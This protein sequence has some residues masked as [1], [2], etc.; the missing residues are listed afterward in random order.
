MRYWFLVLFLTT[1][2]GAQPIL[3]P[4]TR[5]VV[6]VVTES[7]QAPTGR[8]SL[9]E[10]QEKWR[11]VGQTVPVTVGKS[12]L[13]WGLGLHRPAP[14]PVKKEGDGRAPAGMFSITHLFGFERGD[15]EPGL[16]W[17]E[18]DEQECVD[19]H[20][21]LHYNQIVSD[22]EVARDWHSSEQMRIPLYRL[23]LVVA[24]NPERVPGAGSCIFIHRWRSAGAPTVG[25]TALDPGEL[26]RV[27]RF[28]SSRSKPI[29]I[30]L[31][32]SVLEGWSLPDVFKEF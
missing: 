3:P 14:G 31:P 26:D 15:W 25:C 11:R 4:D 18:L 10:R 6:L 12:G 16:P 23:G 2:E 24:H 22:Q 13:G 29:L 19:D 17:V 27:C 30:Q 7:W 21:S 9:F 28:L 1:L 20:R 8:L 32:A 5:Q